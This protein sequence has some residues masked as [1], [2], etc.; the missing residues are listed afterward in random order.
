MITSADCTEV[1][2]VVTAVE[3]RTDPAFCN[4]QPLL[5]PNAPPLCSA[6][7]GTET[8]VFNEDFESDP[9]GSWTLTN[10]GVFPEYT[11]RD[12]EWQGTLP[13]GRPGMA[14]FGLDSAS[15]G[16]CIPGD[17]DQS[18]VMY[19]DSPPI[20][21]PA[22]ATIPRMAFDH[23][24]AT[25][26]LWD[27]GNVQISVN[28]G[29]WTVIS[30]THFIF[31]PY[32]AVLNDAGAGNTNPL[33]GQLAFSGTDGGSIGGSWGQSQLRL[34]AYAQPGDSVQLRYALGVDGC[35]GA[36]GWYVDDVEV[37][38]CSAE[39]TGVSLT[40]FEGGEQKSVW[41]GLAA[42]LFVVVA[43]LGVLLFRRSHFAE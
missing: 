30:V 19:M 40:D 16:N 5:D 32:N 10:M 14:M 34:S 22:G 4:F 27:G 3:F 33:A 9:T 1:G 43:G 29:P 20:V 7:Q 26:S 23:W 35:N 31:N 12:W 42:A 17:D 11:P 6:E 25:E 38:Y 24:H 2:D 21:L 28:G 18:G 13:D 15:L 41:L 36:V 37:F 8:P 39:P